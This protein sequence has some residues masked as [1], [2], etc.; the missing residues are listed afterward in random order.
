[1][2]ELR[3][4][5]LALERFKGVDRLQLSLGGRNAIISGQNGT[6]KTTV[7]DGYTWLLTRKLTNGRAENASGIVE[8]EFTDGT[9]LR[10]ESDGTSH[11]FLNGVPLKAREYY[12]AVGELTGGAALILALPQNFCQLHWTERRA[13]LMAQFGRIDAAEVVAVEPA[14]APLAGQLEQWTPEQIL[15]RNGARI[16]ALRTEL[17]GIPARIDELSRQAV[18]LDG[19]ALQNEVAALS[20]KLTEAGLAVKTE[21]GKLEPAK[22]L[23]TAI[24]EL[25]SG[26]VETTVQARAA[27]VELRQLRKDWAAV[28]GALGGMCPVCGSAIAPDKAAELKAR[29]AEI[30]ARGKLL[31]ERQEV[32]TRGA[33]A[34]E[35]KIAELEVQ[36]PDS[37]ALETA[38]AERDRLAEALN[39]AKLGLTR[40]EAAEKS[41]ARVEELKAAEVELNG[42][43]TA[44]ES[45]VHLAQTFIA[46]KIRLIEDAVNSQFERVR[47]RMYEGYKTSEG[48]R[49]CCEPE[50]NG[51]GYGSL[52]KGE[53]L[54]AA[55][56]I[57]RT[58]QRAYGVQLPVFID[59]AESYTSNTAIALPNQVIRLAAAEGDLRVQVLK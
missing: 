14:L 39:A 11:F 18:T 31:V 53:R 17:S 46:T 36:V 30:V 15:A 21:Q 27:E 56:D 20:K 5:R 45:E 54:M 37:R 19:A 25:Q 40:V 33:A 48:V 26:I 22:A 43:I 12:D 32:L 10:R 29:L 9:I 41:R 59:D 7:A 16:K 6:G 4:E 58:L 52:S 49:E 23:R 34:A 35:A 2:K 57:L 24:Q 47:F 38:L 1:M 51:V 44:L 55:L 50:I 13:I 42:R 28:N 3:L 8:A